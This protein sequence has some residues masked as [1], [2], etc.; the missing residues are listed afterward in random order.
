MSF[1]IKPP[2]T[3]IAVEE[4]RDAAGN[5]IARRVGEVPTKVEADAASLRKR[6]HEIIAKALVEIDEDFRGLSVDDKASVIRSRLIEWGYDIV[7]L[8]ESAWRQLR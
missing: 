8:D 6:P 2:A 4:L 7:P 1:T 3:M 5:L